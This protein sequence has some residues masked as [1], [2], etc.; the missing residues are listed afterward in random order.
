MIGDLMMLAIDN[1]P[2]IFGEVSKQR[3][4][5]FKQHKG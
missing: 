5:G 3:R 4:V 2:T 1:E